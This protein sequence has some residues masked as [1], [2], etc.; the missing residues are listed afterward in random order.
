MPVNCCKASKKQ[1]TCKRKSDSKIFKL[2]RRF[3]QKQCLRGVKG[4]T[5]RSSCAPYKDCQQV[6]GNVYRATAVINNYSNKSNITSINGI[7]HFK[8]KGNKCKISYDISGLTDGKHGFHIHRCGDISKGCAGGCNHFNPTNSQH[9]GSHSK[10]RHAGDLGNIIAK[11]DGF[12]KGSVTVKDLSCDHR[13]LK[14]IIGRMI[15]IHKDEDDL[16]KGDNE[17]SLKTGNAGERIACAVIG[18]AD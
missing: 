13:S 12:A 10:Q 8:S 18:I 5:M 9:G 16:G 2:P 7:I 15:I 14:S 1:K 3:T 4:F 6:K 17:E 11:N